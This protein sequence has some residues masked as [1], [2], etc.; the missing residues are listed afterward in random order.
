MRIQSTCLVALALLGCVG[1]PRPGVPGQPD[2]RPDAPSPPTV[3]ALA[4]NGDAGALDATPTPPDA[5]PG[6]Q[7]PDGPPPDLGPDAAPPPPDLAR[8]QVLYTA[9]CGICH[10]DMGQGYLADNANALSNPNFLAAADDEFLT[11]STVNG[12]PGTPMSAW[13]RE[14]GGPLDATDVRNVVAF[15]RGWASDPV[16]ELG[17]ASEGSAER[18]APIYADRCAECHGD[19]GQGTLGERGAL[20]LNNPWFLDAASDG[21][22]RYAIEAGRPTTRMDPY[23]GVLT[24]EEIEDLVALIRSWQRPPE[25][26][27]PGEYV[28]EL[29]DMVINPGGAEPD[30]ELREAKFVPV[31]DVHAAIEAGETVILLD[32][33]AHGDYLDG[34]LAGAISMPFYLLADYIDQFPRDIWIIAYCGCPHAVSGRAWE[35][36]AALGFEKIAVLDEGYYVWLERGYPVRV[37]SSP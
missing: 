16:V 4:L 19:E 3:D 9:Y 34:H 23:T 6:D 37:G 30:F 5:A 8:G 21:F 18:G 17:P 35:A 36:F 10:G 24:P 31:D 22:I 11:S 29:E 12:R 28:P 25:E 33:R 26:G 13:G 14:Q 2:V 7:G 20:S 32:A 27:M 15:V 1:S